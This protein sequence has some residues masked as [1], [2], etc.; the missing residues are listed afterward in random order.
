[1]TTEAVALSV[2][3]GWPGASASPPAAGDGPKKESSSPMSITTSTVGLLRATTIPGG[4]TTSIMEIYINKYKYIKRV[5]RA[6]FT[7][8]AQDVFAGISVF[9]FQMSFSA[10]IGQAI[11]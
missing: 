8:E 1:M 9:L 6:L 2:K 11:K 3:K 4:E 7:P 5:N 10:C